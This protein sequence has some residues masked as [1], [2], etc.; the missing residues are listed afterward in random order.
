MIQNPVT[1]IHKSV[2]KMMEAREHQLSTLPLL[3]GHCGLYPSFLTSGVFFCL[4]VTPP[5]AS[6]L[7]LFVC[8]PHLLPLVFLC[9]ASPSVSTILGVGW[10]SMAA[11]FSGVQQPALIFQKCLQN[12]KNLRI[13]ALTI[14]AKHLYRDC[15]EVRNG[16]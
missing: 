2:C 5:W 1:K 15:W 8:I 16:A 13:P 12:Q 3:S 9:V 4:H 10:P 11:I 7:C 14:Q 6:P